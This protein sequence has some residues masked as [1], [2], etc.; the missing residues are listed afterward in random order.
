MYGVCT[1]CKVALVALGWPHLARMRD[2]HQ[3]SSSAWLSL[4]TGCGESKRATAGGFTVPVA[5]DFTMQAC[6]H[7]TCLQGCH[8]AVLHVMQQ[9]QSRASMWLYEWCS[10]NSIINRTGGTKCLCQPIRPLA[11]SASAPGTLLN[12]AHKTGM[13]APQHLPRYHGMAA[14]DCNVN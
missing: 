10:D 11:Q 14:V 3:I 5:G 13:A 1:I 7:L 2:I 6:V 4:L 12:T 8:V 9:L